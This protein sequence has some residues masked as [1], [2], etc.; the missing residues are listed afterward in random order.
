MSTIK[1]VVIFAKIALASILNMVWN[2][3]KND[4]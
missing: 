2:E 4:K 1:H 3:V